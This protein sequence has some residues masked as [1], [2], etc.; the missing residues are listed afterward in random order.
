MAK[1]HF[2]NQGKSKQNTIYQGFDIIAD[3]HNY[4][5]ESFEKRILCVVLSNVHLELQSN[6]VISCLH[7]GKN[8]CRHHSGD[9]LSFT[10][11]MHC[12]RWGE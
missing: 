4:M 2:R 12:L 3:L 11:S 5:K 6:P 9:L 10:I 8:Y 1:T 7:A